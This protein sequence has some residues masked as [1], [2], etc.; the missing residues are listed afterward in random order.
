MLIFSMFDGS[1]FAALPWAEAGH[2]VICFNA[3][4]GDHGDYQSVRVT[5][6]NI[7]YVNAWID[8]D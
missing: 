8:S 2:K 5:H 3:D 1:G 7:T 6:E 4:E